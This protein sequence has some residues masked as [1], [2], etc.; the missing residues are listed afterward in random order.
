MDKKYFITAKKQM[1]DFRK[2]M[3]DDGKQFFGEL[4][5]DLFDKNP[6]LEYFGW[7]QY[8]PYFN[9]GDPCVFSANVDDPIVIFSTDNEEV[10]ED[11][12][13]DGERYF[14][15]TDKS[16]EAK[17]FRKVKK[18]LKHFDDDDYE[19][20]FGDHVSVKVMRD[21]IE[22]EEYSHD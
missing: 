5:K 21:E 9:D 18:L 2:K 4:V 17:I 1:K 22:V 10:R 3:S 11:F 15:D 20:L 16:K 13:D 7:K 12:E 14:V 19:I 6:T 8:T